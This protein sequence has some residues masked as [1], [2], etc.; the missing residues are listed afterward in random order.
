[1]AMENPRLELLQTSLIAP[2]TPTQKGHL[3]LSSLDLV[4]RE[5]HFIRRIIFYRMEADQYAAAVDC[6][7]RCL[8]EALVSFYPWAGRFVVGED[9]RVAVDCNDRG[10]EFIE[11]AIDVS[12]R[13]LEDDDF[14]LKP[15]FGKLNHRDEHPPANIFD[16]PLLSIQVTQFLDGGMALGY[17]QSH[18]IADGHS[19]WH[20]M[21]SWAECGRGVPISVPPLHDRTVLKIDLPSKDRAALF[22]FDFPDDFGFKFKDLKATET[23]AGKQGDGKPLVSAQRLFRFT[24]DMIKKLKTL[25]AE[26]GKGDFTSYEVLCAHFW[27]HVTAARRVEDNAVV[28]L[29]VLVNFRSC[30]SDPLP[31]SYFGNVINLSAA[32]AIAGQLYS[33]SLAT[34]ASRIR[35]AVVR[36][37]S[38]DRFWDFLHFLEVHDNLFTDDL[39]APMLKVVCMNVA[40]SFRFP[41][42]EVDFGWGR[43]AAV[44]AARITGGIGEIVLFPGRSGGG[45]VDVCMPLEADAMERLGSDN[46]FLNF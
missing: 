10:V 1:M 33:E 43:P 12:F 27:R 21:N 2:A 3:Y 24:A 22:N 45:S 19:I 31:P 32:Y 46:T 25:A 44:R 6:L 5:F 9:G 41:M 23:T 8:S 30:L 4:W 34:S 14:E 38:E 13:E 29:A 11:A 7:K 16:N 15:F 20:F 42:Y 17:A 39:L 26:E 40:S 36:G 35:E 37:K 18:A 28:C